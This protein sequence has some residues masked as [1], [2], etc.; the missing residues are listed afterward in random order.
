[1]DDGV[2]A[3]I[4]GDTLIVVFRKP[5]SPARWAFHLRLMERMA[6]TP[7]GIL[8]LLLIAESSSPPDTALRRE[9]QAAF[10]GLGPSMRKL[11]VVPMGTSIWMSVVRTLVRATLLL[12]GHS[13]RQ[14]VAS[15]FD[16]ALDRLR[17]LRPS[18]S[19]VEIERCA[20]QLAVE[21]GLAPFHSP[22]VLSRL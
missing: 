21:L 2:A 7:G 11:V 9:M 8:C 10:R 15:S 20:E 6:E 3:A 13:D 16:D 19:L 5:A 22:S 17:E 14:L 1:M 12:S 18:P 4:L